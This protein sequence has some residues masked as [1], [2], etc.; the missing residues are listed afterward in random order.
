MEAVTVAQSET[1]IPARRSTPPLEPGDH[2]TREEFERRFDAMPGL[3]KAELIEGVVYMSSPVRL[4]RHASP[5]AALIGWL[6][7]YWAH[8]PGVIVGDNATV[9]LD[10]D[11]MPQPDAA[12][13]I[14]PARGGQ[15]TLSED[16]YV[17]GAP[18]LVV[19]I[20]A[21]TASIDLN[22]KLRVYRRNNVREYLV[23]RVLDRAIDW[24]VLR[25]GE[26]DRLPIGPDGLLRSEVFPGLWLDPTALIS[27]DLVKALDALQLG[28][29]SPAHADFLDR[30]RG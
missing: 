24:F 2:L 29:A 23:W 1:V 22:T 28:I 10:G 27:S 9:R 18:E 15:A 5:H 4:N 30:L 11:N 14:E 12:M 26:Y 25:Q 17:E 3:K 13:L 6:M 16:D 20:A 7:F 8:T 21:S 19:E